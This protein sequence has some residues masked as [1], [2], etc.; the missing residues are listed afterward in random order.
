MYGFLGYIIGD[1]S[2]DFRESLI[3]FAAA[4]SGFWVCLRRSHDNLVVL[5]KVHGVNF[6]WEFQGFVL[7]RG[8][9]V[10]MSIVGGFL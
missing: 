1:T 6:M 9:G 8:G 5:G 4:C 2:V 7:F 3:V 10:L